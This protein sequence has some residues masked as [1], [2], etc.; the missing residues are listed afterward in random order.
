M[1]HFSK[2]YESPDTIATRVRATSG[3]S[4]DDIEELIFSLEET[5]AAIVSQ[6]QGKAPGLDKVPSDLFQDNIDVWT[7]YISLV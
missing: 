7:P 6:N 1:V 2:L 5:E 3:F 4:H